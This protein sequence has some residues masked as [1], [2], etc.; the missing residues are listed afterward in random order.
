MAEDKKELECPVC[1]ALVDVTELEKYV[2]LDC[3]ECDSELEY[4][5]TELIDIDY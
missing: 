4:T 3:H 1:S 5:G 2:E